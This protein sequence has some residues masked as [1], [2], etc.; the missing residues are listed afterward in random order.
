MGVTH[1]L[2]SVAYPHSNTRAELGVKTTKRML[3]ENVGSGGK[4]DTNSFNMALMQYRN[5]PD[6]TGVSPAMAVFGRQIRDFCPVTPN[7]YEPHGSWKHQM[8][9]REKALRKRHVHMKERLTEHTKTLPNLETG[10]TVYVQNQ[11]G[12]FPRKWD[13]TGVIV[14][15][16]PHQQYVIRLDGSRRA[17]L[18]NRKFIREYTPWQD[19]NIKRYN[20]MQMSPRGQGTSETERISTPIN[21]PA[22]TPNP[23]QD[24]DV[25]QDDPSTTSS[26]DII[27]NETPYETQKVTTPI[28][29]RSA[30][31]VHGWSPNRGWI[32]QPEERKSHHSNL[33]KEEKSLSKI[34]NNYGLKENNAPEEKTEGYNLRPRKNMKS[35]QCTGGGIETGTQITP[36]YLSAM[37]PDSTPPL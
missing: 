12:N 21:Q 17:T 5:T 13:K 24:G 26:D 20:N 19:N 14:E 29:R 23:N 37:M 27:W 36:F 10:T 30:G 16:R 1:R 2:S 4:L 22:P 6:K 7:K 35:T 34:Y 11:M 25:R 33:S 9:D 8:E 15:S 32:Q 3:S 28:K 31:Q 18:R